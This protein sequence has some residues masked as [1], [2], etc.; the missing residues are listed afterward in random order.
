[1]FKMKF[2]ILPSMFT[3]KKSF[4]GTAVGAQ[5]TRVPLKVKFVCLAAV[6]ELHL[7]MLRV[8]G[9]FCVPWKDKLLGDACEQTM[10]PG[11]WMPRPCSG[12][13]QSHL[14]PIFQTHFVFTTT[15]LCL[16]NSSVA[17]VGVLLPSPALGWQLLQM[18]REWE[19]EGFSWQRHEAAA[20]IVPGVNSGWLGFAEM[21][22]LV[23][24]S[25]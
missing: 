1:M 15:L 4:F 5:V 6:G 21:G 3:T 16:L 8:H 18:L 22:P 14:W 7:I 24:N 17:M 2:V 19:R 23:I 9:D 25:K 13:W 11:V 20:P 12:W 10:H